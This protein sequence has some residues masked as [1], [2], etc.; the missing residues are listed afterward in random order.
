[1]S[2]L[3]KTLKPLLDHLDAGHMRVLS[4]ESF[5]A[6][7]YN[8]IYT[9]SAKGEEEK[10]EIVVGAEGSII[11]FPEGSIQEL[12]HPYIPFIRVIGKGADTKRLPK[13]S[14]ED[15]SL[16]LYLVLPGDIYEETEM[17]AYKGAGIQISKN[18]CLAV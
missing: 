2:E 1:M 16:R 4:E 14:S 3:M 12:F 10:R 6:T 8:R 13:R 9:F 7:I 15:I 18:I 17:V 11:R 5:Q